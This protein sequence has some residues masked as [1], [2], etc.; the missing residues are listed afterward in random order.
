MGLMLKH[1][2]EPGPWD[3]PALAQA[4]LNYVVG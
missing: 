3:I 2:R 1:V 4:G